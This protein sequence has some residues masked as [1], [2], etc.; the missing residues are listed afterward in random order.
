MSWHKVTLP[1]TTDIDPKVVHL[2]DIAKACYEKE[3]R[4]AGFAM[5]H[6][7][8]SSEGGLNDTRLVYFSPLA[9]ELC[10]EEVEKS[11]TFEPC[12]VPARDEPGAAWVFGDP[13]LKNELRETWEPETK[14]AKQSV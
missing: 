12:E 10:R 1:L 2:G 4:P 8:R 9:A 6:A 5:M 3:S 13:L 7:S 14:A 11:Y